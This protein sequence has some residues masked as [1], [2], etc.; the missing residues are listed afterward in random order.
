LM[1]LRLCWRAPLT[2]MRSMAIAKPTILADG[3]SR[4][5]QAC[6]ISGV[7]ILNSHYLCSL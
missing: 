7:L 1:F 2:L 4:G 3:F 5:K 6:L